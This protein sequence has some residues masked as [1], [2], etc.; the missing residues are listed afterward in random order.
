MVA[1]KQLDQLRPNKNDLNDAKHLAE[2]QFILKRAKSYV[3]NPIYTELQD[4]GRLYQQLNHDI[5]S[6]KK[7]AT[8]FTSIDFSGN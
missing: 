7:S 8:S 1:K 5:M 6:A 3:Q 2:T 4:M